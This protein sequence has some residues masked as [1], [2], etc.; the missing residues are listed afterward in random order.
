[1]SVPSEHTSLPQYCKKVQ[2]YLTANVSRQFQYVS[3]IFERT[4]NDIKHS[5]NIDYSVV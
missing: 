2:K 1:M 5:L 3:K 4:E